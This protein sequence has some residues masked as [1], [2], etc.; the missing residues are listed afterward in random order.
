MPDYVLGMDGKLYYGADGA[1]LAVLT[2]MTNVRDLNLSMEAGEADVTTRANNRWRATATTLKE[3]TVE[4]EM[5]WKPSDAG[6]EA[7]RDAYLNGVLIE[8]AVLDGD[9]VTAGTEGPR[10]SWAI[11]RFGRNEPLEEGMTVPV[12]AKLNTF[13]EWVEVG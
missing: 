2:E 13:R 9:K 7:I 6:F 10:G 11:T 4:W 5:L 12:T 8:L 1:A 3:A